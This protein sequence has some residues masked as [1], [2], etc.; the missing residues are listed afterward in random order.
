MLATVHL[1]SKARKL[2]RSKLGRGQNYEMTE[3]T[4]LFSFSF[5][6]DS[7]MYRGIEQVKDWDKEQANLFCAAA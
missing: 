4:S 1:S 6:R 3:L 5:S 7:P 2:V